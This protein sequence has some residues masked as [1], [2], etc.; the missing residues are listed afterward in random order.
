MIK[1]ALSHYERRGKNKVYIYV[2]CS[3]K[4]SRGGKIALENVNII[5]LS[6]PLCRAVL[7]SFV[8]TMKI[9]GVLAVIKLVEKQV[10]L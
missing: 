2:V 9:Y 7:L 3:V 1:T 10:F 4:I 5:I 6:N 8:Y